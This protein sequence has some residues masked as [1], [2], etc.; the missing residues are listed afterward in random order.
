MKQYIDLLRKI[1]EDGEQT[2]DRTGTGTR[3]IFGAQLRYDLTKGFPL[4]TTKHVSFK[5]ACIDLLWML[6]GSTNIKPLND[7]GVHIWDEWAIDDGELGPIYGNLW[8][9]F[10]CQWSEYGIDQITEVI[11]KIKTHPNSRSLI[12]TSVNPE[13]MPDET[14]SPQQNVYENKQC[15]ASCQTLFQFKVY[16]NKISLQLYQRSADIFLGVPINL[17][18]YSLLLHLVAHQCD[19]IPSE[20]IHTF[21]DVH[22]YNNH[23]DQVNEQLSR[24]PNEVLPQL[25]IKRKP[26]SIFEYTFDDFE[27]I[28]YNN[29]GRIK[30]PVSV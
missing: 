5:V 13:T 30:A 3:S 9:D 14:K 7:Q 21:G 2:D 22:I 6:S 26:N 16:G 18:Q 4:L 1:K 19:L 29:Y 20:F 10:P 28:N 24:V 25:V 23:T 15:L 17:A 11:D 8:R 27:I 12:V